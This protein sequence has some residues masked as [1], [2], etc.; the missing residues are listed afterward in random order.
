MVVVITGA[1][2]GIG[3][4]LAVYLAGK[5]ARLT[6]TAR[7]LDRLQALNAELGGKHQVIQADV[8]NPD[9]CRNL[10][11]SAAQFH[12][13]I[14]TLVCNAG[15][16]LA[17][18]VADTTSVDLRKIFETNLFGTTDC[19]RAAIPIM[20]QQPEQDG[21]RGQIMIVS[22]AVARRGIPFFGAYSAT[23]A[24]QLSIAESLRVEL[25]PSRIAVTSVHPVGTETEFF[26]TAGKLGDATVPPPG[27]V[28]IQQTAEN[29]H[30]AGDIGSRFGGHRTAQLSTI[31]RGQKERR[32]QGAVFD[33]GLKNG[34]S[35][36]NP[37]TAPIVFAVPQQLPTG[38][39]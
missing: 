25:H 5:G 38:P 9:D 10:V 2:S 39:A 20:L 34:K 30:L 12:G 1:S 14:D 3:R 29:R 18:S 37:F 24:A 23:K 11:A 6:L 26:E 31:G 17:K 7:R 13:R 35:Q 19:L 36:R 8:S 21:W 22:S 32:R 15:Y 28:E 33:G 16:G 4:A 27:K